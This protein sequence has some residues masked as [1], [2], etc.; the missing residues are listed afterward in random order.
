[1]RHSKSMPEGATKKL[2]NK[3]PS[4]NT[5]SGISLMSTDTIG[6]YKNQLGEPQRP[7]HVRQTPDFMAVPSTSSATYP[8]PKPRPVDDDTIRRYLKAFFGIFKFSHNCRLN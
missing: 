7:L 8:E 2:T 1:M 4:I 3:W 6:K 5:D